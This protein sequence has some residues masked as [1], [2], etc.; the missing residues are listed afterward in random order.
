M[1]KS[2]M[3]NRELVHNGGSSSREVSRSV[4]SDGLAEGGL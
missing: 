3:R 4:R 1:L 2:P